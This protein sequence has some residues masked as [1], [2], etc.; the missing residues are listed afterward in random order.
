MIYYTLKNDKYEVRIP[1]L[2]YGVAD[3][4]SHDNDEEYFELLD[5]YVELGGSCIDT[6]RVYC[7]WL[8]NG[9]NASEGVI[10]R[11][12]KARKCRDKIVLATKGGHPEMEHMNENRLN[13]EELTKDLN[14]SL[15]CLGVD[16][17]DIYFLHRDDV[18]VPVEEI[19]PVLNDFYESGKIHFIGVSNWT[20]SRIE[21]A[22]KYAKEHGLEPIRISQ[23]RYS[24]AHA[25]TGTFGDDTLVCM[26]LKQYEWYKKNKFPIMAFSPQAKGFFAK[27]AR[28]DQAKNL[29]EGQYASTANLARLAKVKALSE[30]TGDMPAVIPIG[31][32]NSQPFFVSSVFASTKIWQIEEDMAAQDLKY[33]EKTVAFLENII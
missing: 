4:C 9:H 30:K 19:M 5:K 11:W 2:T 6:A 13:R 24:L 27:F 28:G 33:D 14:E 17:V 21:E 18:T 3:F 26:D 25:S 1:A 20:V 22:N 10:G 12:L 16:Y 31:Y 32:L 23:I 8:E 29:P 15:E 7:D